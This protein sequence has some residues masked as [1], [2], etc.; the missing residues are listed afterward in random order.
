MI[1][2]WHGSNTWLHVAPSEGV[3]TNSARESAKLF[4]NCTHTS[5]HISHRGE[6]AQVVFAAVTAFV[7]RHSVVAGAQWETLM[8]LLTGFPQT[9]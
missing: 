6:S 4:G 5:L 2:P 3:W 1:Y 8:A 7:I 9:S